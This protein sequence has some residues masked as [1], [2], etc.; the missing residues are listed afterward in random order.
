MNATVLIVLAQV[1]GLLAGY[2]IVRKPDE[3]TASPAPGERTRGYGLVAAGCVSVIAITA[4]LNLVGW[5]HLPIA[6]AAVCIASLIYLPLSVAGESEDD[7]RPVPFMWRLRMGFVVCLGS[8]CLAALS[9]KMLFL[10]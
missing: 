8:A 7:D 10:G 5:R 4:A 9:V 3:P 2:A 6:L 1:V